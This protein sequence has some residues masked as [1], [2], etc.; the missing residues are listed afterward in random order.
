MGLFLKPSLNWCVSRRCP[1]LIWS[2]TFFRAWQPGVPRFT[3][4]WLIPLFDPRAHSS[5]GRA[6]HRY[7]G[8]HGFEFRVFQASSFQLLKLEN[9]LR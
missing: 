8:G 5:I 6:S 2:A 1:F 3:R 4:G 7:R 9:L